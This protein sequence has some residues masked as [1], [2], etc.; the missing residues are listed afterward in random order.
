MGASTVYGARV[1]DPDTAAR[2]LEGRL[3]E[4]L[5]PRPVEVVNAGVPGWTSGETLLH[6]EH[7]VLALEPDAVVVMDGRNEVFP[8]LFRHYRDDYTHFRAVEV[9]IRRTHAAHKAVFRVS[10]LALLLA[11]AG[12]G[13]F[14]FHIEREN[15]VYAT[16]RWENQPT[17]EEAVRHASEP[18]RT[19][20]YRRHLEREVALARTH[21]VLPVL[22]TIPFRAE[23]FRSGVLPREETLLE[24]IG[25]LV[26]RNNEIVRETARATG[27]LLVDAAPQLATKTY[28][29]DDCHFNPAG[30]RAFAGVLADALA[31]P[32]A[33]RL[34]GR[35]RGD[36]G[37]SGST[38]A[39]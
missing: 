20:G 24:A 21:G 18:E 15:P 31:A 25:A 36:G 3:A 7:R 16:I 27:A 30:E 10:H 19:R 17:A 38:G 9:D 33:A 1:D 39:P 4:R 34:A 5:A 28:L 6:L 22:V 29:A 14:G 8:Q 32:L 26:A 23:A 11:T 2:L 13:H 35:A 12:P 37:A